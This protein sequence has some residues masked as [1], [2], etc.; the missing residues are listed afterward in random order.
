MA[1][2]AES[3]TNASQTESQSE[4]GFRRVLG[5]FSA[6]S[7]V[8]GAIVGIG[9]FFTPQSIARS[10]G[11]GELAM[12]AWVVG[13]LIALVGA[14]TFAELG[15]LYSRTAGQYEILRDAYGAFVG[16][17]YVFCNATIV[18]AGA[19]AVIAYY[20]ALN[21]GIGMIPDVQPDKLH[22]WNLMVGTVMIVGLTVA[23]LI[24]VRW[25]AYLQNVTVV[26]KLA[27]LLAITG[28][29]IF[30]RPE[31]ATGAV[32]P[33]ADEPVSRWGFLTAITITLFS[34]GGWQQALWVGGEI[35][36]PRRNVPRAIIFGVL[37]VI[38]IYLLVNWAYLQLLGYAR[39]VSPDTQA[40]AA[41]AVGQVWPVWGR[42]AVA[43]AVAF[44]GFGV[45]NAQLLTGPRLICGMARDGKFF[46]MFGNVHAR[47][48]TPVAAILMLGGLGLGLLLGMEGL[49]LALK[50]F[51][52]GDA[53]AS[54]TGVDYID[55]LTN[56]VVLVDSV[57]FMLTGLAVIFL[58]QK[59]KDSPEAIRM[60]LYPL[61]PLLFAIGELIVLIGAFM[62]PKYRDGA[63]IGLIWILMAAVFYAV[64]FRKSR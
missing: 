49:A 23:N 8:I 15:S 62:L 63:I 4:D 44:S 51:S 3:L 33:P 39:M 34:Y 11:S 43:L 16:F 35:R 7:V 26:A 64:F 50:M 54:K 5:P 47:W 42:R 32:T 40:L 2:P 13:G 10:A 48:G 25:G 17:V 58:R 61:F 29:A 38:A 31:V 57:L 41:D 14:L 6:M 36:D 30:L 59:F 21:F 45:L 53:A 12:A 28:L 18:Q 19:I 20:T 22:Q 60:P 52:S 9:I 27:T 24:G 56:G 55:S 37:V 1:R 46:S